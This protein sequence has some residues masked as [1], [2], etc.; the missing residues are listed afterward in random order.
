MPI[1][2]KP[3]FIN[4]VYIY[5]LELNFSRSYIQIL[6]KAC[7]NF[8][9]IMD[10]KCST[11]NTHHN[12]IKMLKNVKIM[13]LHYKKISKKSKFPKQTNKQHQ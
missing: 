7:L 8:V 9:F 10:L 6:I 11:V 5:F 3:V 12:R 1:E 2:I 13:N 4:N